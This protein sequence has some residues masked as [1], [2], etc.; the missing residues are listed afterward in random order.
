MRPFLLSLGLGGALLVAASAQTPSETAP[1]PRSLSSSVEI[2]VGQTFRNFSM[3][4]YENGVLK[5]TLS[6]STATGITLNRAE[7]SDVK[8]DLYE[9]GKVTTTITS[10]KADLYPSE[11]KM[12]TKYTV[13]IE[14]ADS[15]A[16]A[17]TCDFDLIT[18]KYLLRENVRVVLKNFD[19]GAA[20]SRPATTAAAPAPGEAVPAPAIGPVPPSGPPG[21]LLDSPGSATETNGAPTPAHGTVT[22]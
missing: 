2:P 12:R 22:P 3:P 11:K 7:G 16:T 18:K 21:A 20:I 14:R 15:E 4:I 10:P 9:Q 1:A 19:A 6:T 17:Q 8:I 13:K 5:E